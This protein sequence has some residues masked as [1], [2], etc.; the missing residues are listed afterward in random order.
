M[1]KLECSGQY[2]CLYK[3]LSP[4]NIFQNPHKCV[5]GISSPS[6]CLNEWHKNGNQQMHKIRNKNTFRKGIERFFSCFGLY[7]AEK[8]LVLW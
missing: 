4:Q 3:I 1:R 8:I 6:I 5:K 7:Y 2:E